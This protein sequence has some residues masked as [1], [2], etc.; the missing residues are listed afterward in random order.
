LARALADIEDRRL[1]A[2]AGGGGGPDTIPAG[3]CVAHDLSLNLCDYLPAEIAVAD[4]RGAVVKVNRKW[5]ETAR[6]GDLSVKPGGWNYIA[7]WE[8]AIGRGCGEAADILQGLRDVL[9]GVLP[10]FLS[11]YSCPF[12]GRHRWYQIAVAPLDVG[13]ERHALLMHVD[14]SAMQRDALTGLPNRKMFDA[15]LD[16]ILSLARSGD[17]HTGVVFVDVNHLKTINDAHGH[18]AGDEA[19]RTIGRSCSGRLD[20]TLWWR[21]SVAMSSAWFSRSATTLWRHGVRAHFQS[22]AGFPVSDAHN[23]VFVCASVGVALY[24]DDGTTADV[25]IQAADRAMYAQKRGRSVA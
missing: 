17:R 21:V 18:P 22:P 8:A 5:K 11:I 24:P 2:R 19:L 10:T 6:H 13:G 1:V 12:D 25:L 15:Q 3:A 7:E 23:S 9:C 14:V 4:S 16:Y 20:R